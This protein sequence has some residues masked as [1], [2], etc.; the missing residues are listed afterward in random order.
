MDFAYTDWLPDLFSKEL[1]M[2]SSQSLYTHI[3]ETLST[4]HPDIHAKRLTNWVWVIVGLIQ[5]RSVH[6]SEIAN[7]IPGPALA[8]GRIMKIRRWLSNKHITSQTLYQPI[9][10]QVLS[11]WVGREVTIILDGC[12]VNGEALQM[13]RLSLSHCYRA[14]PLAWQVVAQA[15]LV[16]LAVCEAMLEHVATL[17]RPTRRVT[18]LADRGFRDRAWAR[19]CRNLGWDYIIRI[20][21]N[22]YI[23]FGD[24]RQIAVEQL[25]VK[26]GQRRYF[27]NVRLTREADWPCNIAITWTRATPKCPSE[28]CVVMTNL[29]AD[30]WVLRHYLKRMHIE[31]SFRDEKSGGFSLDA[32]HLRDPKRLDSLLLA[33]AVAVL[34]M[35]EIGEQVIRDENRCEIDPGYK[36]Q[37]SV[38]QLGWRQLR[39]G[40]SCTVLPA[41]TL[42][43]RP[44]KPEPVY[45]R[46]LNP[47]A[48]EAAIVPQQGAAE[49]C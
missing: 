39:R 5:A 49:K 41:I 14:L 46:R 45:N 17:L 22:T 23:T 30:G 7:H 12:F 10:E 43:L 15:G 38:F 21:N 6:L 24:G 20:A 40:L 16:E 18:F 26:P 8:A 31:E 28:L 32:T 37:L 19:K 3:L 1:S 9:I 27:P 44:F 25:G 29:H 33:I 42:V 47:V 2:S 48:L 13:L 35:Y 11:G 4:F 34:W 36:R